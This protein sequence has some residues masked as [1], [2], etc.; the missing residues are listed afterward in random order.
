MD[1]L[2]HYQNCIIL[3]IQDNGIGMNNKDKEKLG[4]I[5]SRVNYLNGELNIFIFIIHSYTVILDS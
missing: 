5:R 1:T 4:S 2:S 3:T